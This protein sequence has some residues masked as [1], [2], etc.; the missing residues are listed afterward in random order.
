M[1]QGNE[2]L[3]LLVFHC[4]GA[5]CVIYSCISIYKLADDYSALEPEYQ[6]ECKPYAIWKAAFLGHVI[7]FFIAMSFAVG[8]CDTFLNEEDHEIH[9]ANQEEEREVVTSLIEKSLSVLKVHCTFFCGPFILVECILSCCYYQAI[10]HGCQEHIE[11]PMTA[12]LIY[13][14]IVMGC[15]SI[16]ACLYC[17]YMSFLCVKAGKRALPSMR[18][19]SNWQAERARM[20][21]ENR[22]TR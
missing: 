4:F 6:S 11:D 7:L 14:I 20:I 17:T 2:Q 10:L 1:S 12:T 16:A 3:C 5:L 22:R 8:T 13:V 18:D 9:E 19:V 21:E 15:I